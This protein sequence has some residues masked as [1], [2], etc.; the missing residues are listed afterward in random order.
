[1]IHHRGR[2]RR[3]SE[4]EASLVYKSEFQDSQ[5][6]R[7]TL[8]LKKPKP[9]P[10]KKDLR[11]NPFPTFPLPHH[12]GNHS[13]SKHNSKEKQANSDSHDGNGVLRRV[14]EGKGKR[15]KV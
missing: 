12:Y 9:K 7:E 6:Y 14:W 15:E 10:N 8:S 3:I 4:F 1:L 13:S 2:G 11:Y 5:G